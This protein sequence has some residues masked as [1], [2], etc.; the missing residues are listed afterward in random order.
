[1]FEKPMEALKA[2]DSEDRQFAACA[3]LTKYKNTPRYV[4]GALKEVEIPKEESKL[5]LETLSE[6]EW[7]VYDPWGMSLQGVWH[8][9]TSQYQNGWVQPNANGNDFNAEMT[10]ATK[11]WLKANAEKFVIKKYVVEKK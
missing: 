2:K 6:M 11:K 10:A 3:L 7:G 8:L 4:Q 9:I 1:V 5:I